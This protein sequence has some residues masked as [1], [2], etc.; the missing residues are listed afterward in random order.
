[1]VI[2]NLIYMKVV[3][4][5]NVANIGKKGD[6]KEVSDGYAKNFLIPQKLAVLAT[7]QILG[8]IE[9][10]KK[11]LEHKKEVAA[12]HA[13]EIGEKLNGFEVKV[14]LKAGEDG[15]PF[16]SVTVTKVIS[17]L[18]KAGFDV[19]KS[20]VLMKENIKTLGAHNIKI[21]LGHGVEATVKVVAEAEK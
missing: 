9:A 7:T 6:I 5:Q 17:A 13:K 19:E 14:P 16:G 20:Q 1:M 18:K 21:D 3:L 2:E 8:R 15:K 11:A 4:L 12:G 10:E